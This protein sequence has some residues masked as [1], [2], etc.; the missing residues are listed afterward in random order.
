[1]YFLSSATVETNSHKRVGKSQ[2]ITRACKID[3]G[4]ELYRLCQPPGSTD[5]DKVVA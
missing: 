3:A 5:L 1:L 2:V 4:I